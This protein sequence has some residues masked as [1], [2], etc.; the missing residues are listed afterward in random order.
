MGRLPL[1]RAETRWE[2]PNCPET[3]LT[4]E[5]H[6]HTR[7]HQC[8]GLHGLTVP[9]VQAGTDCKV[10]AIDREDYVGADHGAVQLAPGNGRPYMAARTTRAD[11]SN[12]TTVYAPVARGRLAHGRRRV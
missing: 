3:A 10:E 7:F 2:C 12:D 11:G 6:P 9:L 8:R 1:L 4:T 5:A